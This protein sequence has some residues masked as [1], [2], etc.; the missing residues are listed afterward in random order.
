MAA[1]KIP[2]AALYKIGQVR[3]FLISGDAGSG[4]PFLMPPIP[5]KVVQ[6]PVNQ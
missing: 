3:W 5:L 4:I 1:A 2:G 6:K